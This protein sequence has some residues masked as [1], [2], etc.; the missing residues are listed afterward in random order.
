MKKSVV[1]KLLL[2]AFV[3][4]FAAISIGATKFSKVYDDATQRMVDGDYS[5]AAELFDSI[6]NYE[7]SANLS[8]YC[9]ANQLA[10]QGEY[11]EAI[12]A[13]EFFGDYKDCKYLVVYYSACQ[14]EDQGAEDPLKYLD[15]AAKFK[16]I[17]LF[18]DSSAR[19]DLCKQKL[20]IAASGLLERGDY[21]TAYF[22]FDS[23]DGYSDSEMRM[24]ECFYHQG[25][26]AL[27]EKKFD[28][29]VKSFELAEDYEDSAEQVVLAHKLSDMKVENEYLLFDGDYDII[30][31]YPDNEFYLGD[32]SELLFDYY[33]MKITNQGTDTLKYSVKCEIDGVVYTWKESELDAGK[34]A[35]YPFSSEESPDYFQEGAHTCIWYVDGVEVLDDTYTVQSGISEEREKNAA[36]VD[37]L[38]VEMAI[39]QY[40]EGNKKLEGFVNGAII[41]RA[42]LLE[43]KEYVPV[44]I[45]NNPSES[46]LS[47]SPVAIID[48]EYC[49][50]DIAEIEPS[51]AHRFFSSDAL[52][53]G[54]HRIQ[55]LLNGIEVGDWTFEIVDSVA[56]SPVLSKDISP[57]IGQAYRFGKFEQDNNLNNGPEDIEWIVLDVQ[58]GRALMISRYALNCVP[59]NEETVDITWEDCSLRTWLNG[60][61]LEAAFSE[62]EQGRIQLTDVDNSD[63]QG[64]GAG[65]ASGGNDT[66]DKLFLL[67]YSEAGDYFSSG[68]SRICR[69]TPYAAAQEKCTLDD[70]GTCFWW[71]RSPGFSQNSATFIDSMGGFGSSGGSVGYREHADRPAM[72][73]MLQTISE[74]NM[75][76]ELTE[77][78]EQPTFGFMSA[79]GSIGSDTGTTLNIHAD[80]STKTI[81]QSTIQID[82]A[83]YCDSS[84]LYT[85]ESPNALHVRV[86]E[87][88]VELTAPMI[89]IKEETKISTLL[90]S[91]SFNVAVDT[92]KDS[93]IPLE[94]TWFYMGTY[95]SVFLGEIE[96]DGYIDLS[97]MER[98]GE[99]TEA[100]FEEKPLTAGDAFTFGTYEQDNDLSNGPEDIEW[101]VLDVQD[102][103]VLLI[104]KHS[105]NSKPYNTELT[106]ATWEASSL[107]AWLNDEFLHTAFTE[108]QRKEILLT[109]VNNS[110]SQDFNGII[111][112]GDEADNTE[113]TDE[114]KNV[115]EDYV[116]LLSFMEGHRYFEESED[117]R[118]QPTPYA[119]DQ[120]AY[121]KDGYGRWWYR[122]TAN[123]AGA[124]SC[125]TAQGSSYKKEITDSH[126]GVR[127]AIWVDISNMTGKTDQRE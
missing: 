104:S 39:A 126:S 59:Y 89:E 78:S 17:S 51:R 34:T 101:I 90:N 93:K 62:E 125:V 36:I 118:C 3:M 25:Q 43:G 102:D 41:S 8:M 121:E 88:N 12:S 19:A 57:E 54:R 103:K 127:P 85:T 24:K 28:L 65:S 5:G 46:N 30:Q 52:K 111:F 10:L 11:D 60:E 1:K 79:S 100:F 14:I 67:S 16:T 7:D 58:D 116:F 123:A 107:R 109:S 77:D 120:G 115:T 61:F 4:C 108:D 75:E 73:V 106:T 20:Y 122:G 35:W 63:E 22:Y 37:S 105:L 96:C 38:D 71:L 87:Q 56:E 98:S 86:G 18:R 99:I 114:I 21:E 80:W 74:E 15:A 119:I 48:G 97:G 40:E 94:V 55:L 76:G 29:A 84:V 82:V 91:T 31:E 66:R 117:R 69:A 44:I 49:I 9:K 45:V 53:N 113:G 92:I 64:S 47:A 32:L 112:L 23:L 42:D 70:T 33:A 50:W 26:D 27:K 68:I 124:I 6:A 83:V 2:C 110:V 13:F 72:W 95:D 81:D